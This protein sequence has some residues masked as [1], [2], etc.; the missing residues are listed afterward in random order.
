MLVCLDFVAIGFMECQVNNNNNNNNNEYVL[1][2]CYFVTP[3]FLENFRTPGV[4]DLLALEKL[5]VGEFYGFQSIV[6]I[7]FS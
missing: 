3:R 1:F 2:E 6:C 4:V 5:E 7:V